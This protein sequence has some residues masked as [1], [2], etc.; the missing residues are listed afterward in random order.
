MPVGDAPAAV[1]PPP[2]AP[3]LQGGVVPDGWIGQ[4]PV[5][6]E[7]EPQRSDG[8]IAAGLTCR[9][10]MAD[11]PLPQRGISHLVEHLTLSA[12]TG[13]S[14]RHNGFV[15]QMTTNFVVHG[16]PAEVAGY[17]ATVC[18]A[19]AAPDAAR[20]PLETQVLRA[21]AARRGSDTA[22]SIMNWRTGAS[23]YGALAYRELFLERPNIDWLRYWIARYFTA[24]NA[25][26]W[27]TGPIPDGL[28]LPLPAGERRPT[29]E[30]VWLPEQYPAWNVDEV[31]GVVLSLIRS[32]SVV[33]SVAVE[34]ARTRLF[35]Q[36]RV[37][38]G[39]SYDVGVRS[40]EL[41]TGQVHTLLH[42]DCVP[43]QAV[44]V[45]DAFV[46]ELRRLGLYGPTDDEVA[47]VTSS[48]ARSISESDGS[49]VASRAR[50]H[51]LGRPFLSSDEVL[52][53]MGSIDTV[54]V[55][56]RLES[57]A[58]TALWVVPGEVG[59]RDHRYVQLRPWSTT[60]ATGVPTPIAVPATPEDR[61]S[62]AYDVS[63]ITV[64]LDPEFRCP[65]TVEFERCAALVCSTNGSRSLVGADGFTVL[66]EPAHWANG[67]ALVEWVDRRVPAERI[68]VMSES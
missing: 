36:L 40:D 63:C 10:G 67:A 24:D 55:R 43:A 18:A 25:V 31:G 1:L 15:D 45:R 52:A 44:K 14:E 39:L 58:D 48:V 30:P 33:D 38:L 57:M 17:F 56:D 34:V 11:E 64:F 29:P 41:G 8:K 12:M 5:F 3:E 2:S 9:V 37:K 4:I 26:F 27:C 53:A 65:V 54:T 19:L 16:T 21:E 47:R 28:S 42:A 68:V 46:T 23:G 62:I 7:V 60:W 59:W 66:I 49:D 61:R 50:A 51:L 32:A 35:D 13:T 22:A 6:Y 20:L